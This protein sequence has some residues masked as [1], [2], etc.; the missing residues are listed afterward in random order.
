[1][2][3]AAPSA[4]SSPEGDRAMK[5]SIVVPTLV[6]I[7]L[8]SCGALV[9]LAACGCAWAQVG[10]SGNA[11]P[12]A[13]GPGSTAVGPVGIPLGA[14]EMATPGLSPALPS[15]AGCPPA[16]SSSSQTAT[17]DG[18]GMAGMASSACTQTDPAATVSPMPTPPTLSAGRAGIPLGSTEITSPG[19][20][21]MPP[22]SAPYV[23][24]MAPPTLSSPA[25]T[26][27]STT[28][29]GGTPTPLALP[30]FT[31][32]HA[33]TARGARSTSAGGAAGC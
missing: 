4:S 5:T 16:G 28:T 2:S 26:G 23:S 6:A 12:F 3:I 18:G 25:T 30:C 20:S 21:P 27:A 32:P 8:A 9:I 13:I 10:G 7:L 11:S 22:P 33:S 29:M 31:P 17:F 15:T 19:L 1:V 24:P 14:T